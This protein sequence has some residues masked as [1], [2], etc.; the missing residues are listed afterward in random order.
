MGKTTLSAG[1]QG[2]INANKKRVTLSDFDNHAITSANDSVYGA[3]CVI[4]I[5]NQET[6]E[7]NPG[8]LGIDEF[9]TNGRTSKAPFIYCDSTE[10]PKKLFISQLIRKV[11]EYKEEGGEF[12]RKE[13]EPVHSDTELYGDLVQ[14]KDAGSILKKVLGKKLK[15]TKNL[16][17][18]TARYNGGAIV[19]LR[20]Y[21]LACFEKVS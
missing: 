12:V 13:G 15:V 1:L 19:G 16:T 21:N 18:K 9:T 5:P 7:D 8:I 3:G 14:L 6:L 20:D 4:T 2:L 10:G 17:G 11:V